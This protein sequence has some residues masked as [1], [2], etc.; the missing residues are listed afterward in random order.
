MDLIVGAALQVVFGAAAI[1]MIASFIAL[2][3]IAMG[4]WPR[5]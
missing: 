3:A 5:R 4:N 2:V 1:V